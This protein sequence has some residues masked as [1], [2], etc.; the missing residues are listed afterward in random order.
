MPVVQALATQV[1]VE[2]QLAQAA[3][4]ARPCGC[5]EQRHILRLPGLR[6]N[7]TDTPAPSWRSLSWVK[8]LQSALYPKFLLG[9]P[10]KVRGCVHSG[11]LFLR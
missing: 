6:G 7:R 4:H 9:V 3:L 8:E 2:L 5:D 11:V 1:P 10:E